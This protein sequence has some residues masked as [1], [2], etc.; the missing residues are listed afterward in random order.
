LKNWNRLTTVRGG[1]RITT[2][3]AVNI[4]CGSSPTPGWLNYDGSPAIKLA[5]RPWLCFLLDRAGLLNSINREYISFARQSDIRW[6]DATKHIPLAS[7]SVDVLY[8]SHMLEHLD[9][10]EAKIF[11]SE[12]YRVLKPGGI[13]RIAVPDLRVIVEEYCQHGDG[14]RLIERTHLGHP[15]PKGIR[16]KLKWLATTARGSHRWMYDAASLSRLLSDSGFNENEAKSAGS[17]S[18]PEPGALDLRER[19]SESLYMEARRI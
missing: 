1:V 6:A 8:S 17:T 15:R 7:G 19:E 4:G 3:V 16:A 9:R 13:I 12:A 2:H 14:N 11:L 5:H 18:I 10:D